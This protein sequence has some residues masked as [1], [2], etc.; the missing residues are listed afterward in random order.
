MIKESRYILRRILIGVGIVLVLS[1]FNGCKVKALSWED[2]DMKQVSEFRSN[3]A[4]ITFKIYY[5]NTFDRYYYYSSNDSL[6]F[7]R[8][9][10]NASDIPYVACYYDYLS[11]HRFLCTFS[12]IQLYYNPNIENGKYLVP[13]TGRTVPYTHLTVEFVTN[14]SSGYSPG[15][16]SYYNI[17]P[18]TNTDYIYLYSRSSHPENPFRSSNYDINYF[19]NINNTYYEKN[20]NVLP[21]VDSVLSNW[22]ATKIT[23]NNV[24][25]RYDFRPEFSNFNTDDFKY[26]YTVGNNSNWLSITE[27]NH[28]IKINNNT[29]IKIRIRN[30]SDDTLLHTY[31]FTITSIGK[32]NNSQNYEI[33]FS[34]EYRTE[35]FLNDNVSSKSQSTIVEYQIFI[36]YLPKSSILKYQYQFVSTDD[37]LDNNN[38]STVSESDNGSITYVANENGSLY[39]RILD[40]ND[41]VLKT[42]TFTV[43]SI[44]L[45]AFDN[46]EIGTNNFF[47]KLRNKINY[48][49]PVSSL[50][51]LPVSFFSNLYDSIDNSNTCSNIQ[52]GS[53]LGNNLSL[54]CVDIPRYL[55]NNV[56]NIIDFIFSF[57][58]LIGI[59]RFV[60]KKY[61]KFISMQDIGD[62]L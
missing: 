18:V 46:N 2:S 19:N 57:I 29:S 13:L 3:S 28:L 23:N 22:N 49:G 54:P 50:F 15:T 9:T 58:L 51:I 14:S 11:Q 6:N 26:S 36:D 44:G 52:L 31:S 37:S 5:N 39:A 61:N 42:A 25:T 53:I 38:W 59:F 41:N 12:D 10:E 27:N 4:N 48:G 62:D 55:G 56:Y 35:N 32:F 33:N 24:I 45:L 17:S 43:N 40:S 47:D 7:N 16:I 21:G 1:F 8:Y 60:I 30:A 34:G 20:Y